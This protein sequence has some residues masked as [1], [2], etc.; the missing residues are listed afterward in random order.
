MIIFRVKKYLMVFLKWF[1]DKEYI[2]LAEYDDDDDYDDEDS[3]VYRI[4]NIF[5]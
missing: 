3:V 4:N 2:C 5:V 1:L